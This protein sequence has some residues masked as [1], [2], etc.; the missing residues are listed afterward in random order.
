MHG[1]CVGAE[2]GAVISCPPLPRQVPDV[3]S[4]F[5]VFPLQLAGW[6]NSAE[7]AE[8]MLG[9][10]APPDT[11]DDGMRTAGHAAAASDASEALEVLLS[12]G[13]HRE[14]RGRGAVAP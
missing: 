14:V 9:A 2:A 1:G 11:R 3:R 4:R 6:A 12:F 7:A 13:A 8:A 5:G 10:G